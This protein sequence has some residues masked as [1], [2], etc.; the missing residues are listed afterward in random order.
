MY[1][2]IN[3]VKYVDANLDALFRIMNQ[4]IVSQL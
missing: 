2:S 4:Y 3:N 1:T